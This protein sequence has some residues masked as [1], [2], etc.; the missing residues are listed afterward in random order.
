M[1]NS[2]DTFETRKQSFISAF[3]ICK[4]V[5]SIKNFLPLLYTSALGYVF[6]HSPEVF[7][8]GVSCSS[9]EIPGVKC[10][11]EICK[12]NIVMYYFEFK[13]YYSTHSV[14]RNSGPFCRFTLGFETMIFLSEFLRLF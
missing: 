2:Q 10:S 7:F 5:P 11:L 6:P 14:F 12:Q 1:R 3:S 9:A 13:S 8:T 4:T